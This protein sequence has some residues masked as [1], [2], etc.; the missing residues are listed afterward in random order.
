VKESALYKRTGDI[1]EVVKEGLRILYEEGLIEFTRKSFFY[2][3]RKFIDLS[4]LGHILVKIIG[5]RFKEEVNKLSD[6]DSFIDLAFSFN[7]FGIDIKP[8]QVKEEICELLKILD[9]VKPKTVL[10]IGTAKG[11]TLFLF[12]RVADSTAK[13]ISIDLPGGS[14]GGGYPKWKIPLY[15]SFANEDQEI[16][17]IR[18]NSHDDRTLK[19]VKRILDD[20]KVDFLFIDGDH[21]Y[22]G[23]KKD[24]KM[25]SSL[26]RKG[27]IIAFH[28]IV[29]HDK[30]HDPAGEVGVPLF[31]SELKSKYAMYLEIVMDW[32][33]GWAGIGVLYV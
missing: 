3:F 32:R 10:E 30:A 15:L 28:D 1:M 8:S 16:H 19:E 26:V 31:W 20:D 27:G 5:K 24:F 4:G 18:A 22:E 29:P 7:S 9:N 17:L 21:T 11:G 13:I 12:A 25:Y 6:I 23:V 14:F 2:I 33:Q